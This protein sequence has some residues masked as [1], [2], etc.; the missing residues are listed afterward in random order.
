MPPAQRRAHLIEVTVALLQDKGSG[1]TTRDIAEAAEVAEGTIFRAFATKDELLA[2]ALR[3]AFDASGWLDQLGAL[4]TDVT[5]REHLLDV[6]A[7]MQQRFT[8]THRLMAAMGMVAIPDE[9]LE[10]PDTRQANRR[11]AEDQM[12]ALAA[13]YEAELR[14]PPREL[15]RT[16]RLLT[17]AGS[18]T[19]LTQ[20]ELLSPEQIVDTALF[21]LLLDNQRRPDQG[22]AC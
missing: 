11:R 18:H 15:V 1:L 3:H 21:G 12:V 19:D 5:L 10:D 13:A 6:V 4:R 7:L 8:S 22:P 14:V 16:V 17:F 9:L 20:G 2:A